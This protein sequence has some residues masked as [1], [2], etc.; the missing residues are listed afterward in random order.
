[1][2]VQQSG[3]LTTWKD[4]RG[5]GFIKPDQGGNNIFLHISAVQRASRRPKVGDI[6]LYEPVL[7]PGGKVRAENAVI[8]GLA[9]TP[10]FRNSQATPRRRTQPKQRSSANATVG[11]GGVVVAVGLV[12][13][14]T[15]VAMERSPSQSPPVVTA[16]TNPACNIK[17]NISQNSGKKW[18][19][20][21]GMEDYEGTVINPDNGERWFCSE[22][23]A[24]A[25]G[26]QKAP[27]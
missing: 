27:K 6:I 20:V 3:K 8:Q 9:H 16:I 17:G 22:E 13:I 18:Y 12:V 15:V 19:H 5:F 2:A 25:S 7:E 10:K 26:W 11:V 21:P 4:D 23:E 24:R 14:T 1:M